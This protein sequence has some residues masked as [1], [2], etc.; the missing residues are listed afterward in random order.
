MVKT[1]IPVS[2]V[3]PGLDLSGAAALQF[4]IGFINLSSVEAGAYSECRMGGKDGEG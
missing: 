1:Y 3:N 4:I 2:S